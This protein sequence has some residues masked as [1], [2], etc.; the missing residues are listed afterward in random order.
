MPAF[1][2]SLLG[3]ALGLG[4]SWRAT[5]AH[6]RPRSEARD[7]GVVALFGVLLLGPSAA[8]ITL[9]FTDWAFG[10][11]LASAP[12]A[13]LVLALGGATAGAPVGFALGERLGLGPLRRHLAWA[14]GG[15]LAL[16]LLVALAPH[17]APTRLA[18]TARLRGGFATA[19]A[20]AS[21]LGVGLAWCLALVAFGAAVVARA[22]EGDEERAEPPASDP[23]LGRARRD[24]RAAGPLPRR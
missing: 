17:A 14:A 16:A 12:T 24:R 23:R 15:A 9:G 3:L 13:L 10:Y 1:A 8:W 11:R 22:L 4:L 20:L 2:F 21:E 7:L 18:T 19:S 5:R 6:G